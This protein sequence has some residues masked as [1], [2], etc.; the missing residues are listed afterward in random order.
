MNA[1]QSLAV[2]L[3]TRRDC[4]FDPP[5]RYQNL[6]QQQPIAPLAFPDGTVGWLL[7]RHEDVRAV[8]ADDRF[9]SD[10][11]KASSPIRR[12]TF[13]PEDS[14]GLLL[15]MDPPQ[16]THYRRML[17]RHFT[18]RR[19]RALAPRI[20]QIVTDH[21]DA[22]CAAGP[23]V[24][25]VPAFARPIPSLVICELLGVPYA[26]RD[27]F[28]QL[29]ATL[30]KLDIP[31][32][33]SR[34][35]RQ[36]LRQYMRDLV[37]AKR[38]RPDDALLTSLIQAAQDPQTA[39]TDEELTGLGVLL[40]VAGHETTA[41]MLA[42]GTYLLLRH[43]DQAH[44]LREHP[45]DVERAVEE[46]LRYLTILQFG[47]VRVARQDVEIGGRRIRAGQTVVLALAAANRDPEHFAHPDELDL[48]REPSQH[49]SFGHGVHQCLGQQLAR[50]EMHIAFPALLR[51]FPTLR[52]AVPPEQVPMRDDMLIYGVHALPLTW[53]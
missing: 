46:L 52:L 17:T 42:L 20:E 53:D 36:A 16:H 10:R 22:M 14:P 48:T 23:P 12:I 13:R 45:E 5:S 47:P 38:R 21:L 50:V 51:R 28:Q 29:T 6:R 7:T 9:S 33:E 31:E 3:P 18:V 37:A 43:P 1:S 26:D 35:A 41:N 44:A 39:L 49:V 32:Q 15:N 19:M 25:L 11:A 27:G 40:L 30:L 24:D 8:L 34:Q 4:P 2:T